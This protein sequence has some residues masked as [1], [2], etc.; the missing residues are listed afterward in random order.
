MVACFPQE[1]QTFWTASCAE[2]G[3]YT[4]TGYLAVQSIHYFQS[5][6]ACSYRVVFTASPLPTTLQTPQ[7]KLLRS[8][9]A[10][11]EV[12]I[13]YRQLKF[14]HTAANLLVLYTPCVAGVVR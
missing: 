8:G 2:E 5:I 4:S 9:T 11:D 12:T 6:S 7:P 13:L 10:S 14:R 1:F 3:V